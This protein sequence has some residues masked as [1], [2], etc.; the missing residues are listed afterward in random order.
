MRYAQNAGVRFRHRAPALFTVRLQ[1]GFEQ[2]LDGVEI[3]KVKH[4]SQTRLAGEY[5]RGPS[6][7]ASFG[8]KKAPPEGRVLESRP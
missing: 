1:V 4:T 7:G 6:R 2:A 8:K 5:S 3:E